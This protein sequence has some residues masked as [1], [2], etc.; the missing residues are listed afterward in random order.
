MDLKKIK[1]LIDL[2]SNTRLSELELIEN[3]ERI[4]LEKRGAG[5]REPGF[6][7]ASEA[8]YLDA[9][10]APV[11]TPEPLLPQTPA[12]APSLH[13]QKAPMH[14]VLHLTPSPGEP[15]FVKVG[16]DVREGQ[17]L[18]VIEAMKMFNTIE[19]E[20]AGKISAI[21]AEAGKEV[22]VGQALFRIE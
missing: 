10:I 3:E 16:D 15:T 8:R 22:E 6:I 1:S 14:G 11:S 2:V 19:A 21:L 20:C 4:R 5:R 13:L 12:P 9:P 7:A 18:C 17:V